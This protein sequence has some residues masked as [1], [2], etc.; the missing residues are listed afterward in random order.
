MQQCG[1]CGTKINQGYS[2]C[3]NCGAQFKRSLKRIFIALSI[4]APLPFIVV[5]VAIIGVMTDKMKIEDY[6][7][8]VILLPLVSLFSYYFFRK[9]VSKR[10][11]KNKFDNFVDRVVEANKR[12]IHGRH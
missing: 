6:I 7:L 9:L 11:T 1:Y 5:Y 4:I 3:S 8:F 12:G 2:T 10:W